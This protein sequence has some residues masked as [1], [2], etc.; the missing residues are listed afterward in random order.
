MLTTSRYWRNEAS[1]PLLPE[2][3]QVECGAVRIAH[4]VRRLSATNLW[5]AETW[6]VDVV[7]VNDNDK[8]SSSVVISGDDGM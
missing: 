6:W 3:G 8:R 1:D 4:T 5:I 2:E 7:K